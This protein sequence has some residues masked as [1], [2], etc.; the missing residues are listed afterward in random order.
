VA[1]FAARWALVLVA[2]LFL[3]LFIARID[4]NAVPGVNHD[5]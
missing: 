3:L 2:P 1:L 5:H 4:G